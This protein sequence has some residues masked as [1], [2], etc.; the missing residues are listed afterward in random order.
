M[1]AQPISADVI[2]ADDT[3]T[4]LWQKS[5]MWGLQG[6]PSSTPA[7]PTTEATQAPRHRFTRPGS[8]GF[9]NQ[10]PTVSPTINAQDPA[11]GVITGDLHA[12]DPEG[13]KLTYAV[14][15]KPDHGTVTVDDKGQF[16]YTPDAST[17]AD[18]GTDSFVVSVSDSQSRPGGRARFRPSGNVTTATVQLDVEPTGHNAAPV[19]N[20]PAAVGQPDPATGAVVITPNVTDPNG[21]A[22]TYSTNADGTFTQNG[23]GT[24][25]YTPTDAERH[26]AAG[27]A[28]PDSKTITITAADGKGGTAS[29]DTNL[30]V[31]PK[32]SAPTN[33]AASGAAADNGTVSGTISGVDADD[34]S[35]TYTG[36]TTSSKGGA[37]QVNADGTYTYTPTDQARY[38]AG[39]P[40]ADTS[41]TQDTFAVTM[42]D[43]HGGTT[44]QDVT[45]GIPPTDTMSIA[46]I[47][48]GATT[49]YTPGT[50]IVLTRHVDPSTGAVTTETTVVDPETG[51][52]TVADVPGDGWA[53]VTEDGKHVVTTTS[54]YNS[55]TGKTTSHL[56]VSN[57]DTG[58]TVISDDIAGYPNTTLTADGKRAVMTS[59]DWDQ[60]TGNYISKVSVLNTET[61]ETIVSDGQPGTATMMI[62]RD[63][64]RAVTTSQAYDSTAG[65]TLTYIT[66]TDLNTGES[67][68]VAPIVGP[69][70]PEITSDG[71]NAVTTAAATDAA[72]GKTTTTVTVTNLDTGAQ[73]TSGPLP[74][75]GN[76]RLNADGTKAITFTS[77]YDPDSNVQPG[78]VTVT[79]VVTGSSTTTA[80]PGPY[81]SS[82]PFFSEDGSTIM[83]QSYDY[84]PSAMKIITH[85]TI[86][87]AETG[88]TTTTSADGFSESTS[89]GGKVISIDGRY[90]DA[91]DSVTVRDLDTGQTSTAATTGE[92]TSTEFTPNGDSVLILSQTVDE[93]TSTATTHISVLNTQTGQTTT[94]DAPG[95]AGYQA[96]QYSDDGKIVAVHTTSYDSAGS[97]VSYVTYTNVETGKSTTSDALV[98]T[99]AWDT[100]TEFLTDGRTVV[101]TGNG[102]DADGDV[103]YVVVSNLDTGRSTTTA[104][105]GGSGSTRISD[106]GTKAITTAHQHPGNGITG[107][108]S[109]AVI[110]LATGESVTASSPGS[111]G[112]GMLT[113]DGTLLVI[114][115]TDTDYSTGEATSYVTTKNLLTGK[116]STSVVPGVTQT[117]LTADNKKAVSVSRTYDR[118]TD[119]SV[120]YVAVT[121]L[122]TG[123]TVVSDGMAGQQAGWEESA[124]GSTWVTTAVDYD[125]QVTHVAVTDLRTGQTTISGPITGTGSSQLGNDGKTV[126]S[127]THY[128][129]D[130]TDTSTTS[131]TLTDVATG[132]S[133]T[134]VSDGYGFTTMS[135]DGMSAVTATNNAG[136]TTY[137]T[138]TNLATGVSTTSTV[139]TGGNPNYSSYS[140]TRI[141]IDNTGA[142]TQTVFSDADGKA[143]TYLTYSDLETGESNSTLLPGSWGTTSLSSNGATA[144]TI[145]SDNSATYYTVTDL[146]T[147]AQSTRTVD[148]RQVGEPVFS[149]DG[150]TMT[151]M[152]KGVD[153]TL[154]LTRIDLDTPTTA[155]SSG[156]EV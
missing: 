120:T 18:G 22:I 129:D 55:S 150:Q 81:S 109:V 57:L 144:I 100:S 51:K 70:S 80:L 30:T 107:S 123:E 85:T 76:T 21:D 45:V 126:L 127:T 125:N 1:T 77:D 131:I 82:N 40:D 27:T 50:T 96:T 121:D 88:E 108:T 41:V 110:D 101:T 61:G 151:V 9:T 32:N 60:A 29:F 25:T 136:G 142:V 19:V 71:K 31:V 87:N 105:D 145:T 112:G 83:A 106:D 49:P 152:T 53:Y 64:S 149:A 104:I 116:E 93:S 124:D 117:E 59:S 86:V 111:Y 155:G 10:P 79:D 72:T 11:T 37:V 69:N 154:H 13:A 74:G 73:T 67:R 153:G 2:P 119:A 43:G 14:T 35:I 118:N 63:Q 52:S 20:G 44:T 89:Y 5:W 12:S 66:V 8:N 26:A 16:I 94:T 4:S 39:N 90:D 143:R 46:G 23:D 114:S 141:G 156:S 138:V 78:Y 84:D 34:D 75:Q 98:G 33:A 65:Q 95:T 38:A 6:L 54:S 24:I 128:F 146:K 15:D 42:D 130:R 48:G 47:S 17:A 91:P 147:G 140:N 36:A 97:P 99:Q 134:K 103:T 137:V 28:D 102:Q 139:P 92:V 3:T 135:A 113:D 56:A 62:S 115:S 58:K 68:A 133:T 132:Q 148:G 7:T 122:E